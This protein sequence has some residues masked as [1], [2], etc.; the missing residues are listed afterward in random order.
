MAVLALENVPQPHW[1]KVF[2]YKCVE[3]TQIFI[4]AHVRITDNTFPFI[5]LHQST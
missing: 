5:L 2:G 4:C 1:S 3:V